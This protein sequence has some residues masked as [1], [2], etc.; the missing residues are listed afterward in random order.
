MIKGLTI[1]IGSILFII[2]AIV[3]I[4][5]FFK[6]S[7][8]NL[9]KTFHFAFLLIVTVWLYAFD[10]WKYSVTTMFVFMLLALPVLCLF[11]RIPFI[12]EH[13]PQR[14]KDEFKQSLIA[15][16]SMYI[17]VVA[18]GWGLMKNRSLCLAAFYAWGPGDGAAALIGKRYGR[19]KIGKLKKKSLEGSASMFILSF[20]CVAAI[21]SYNNVFTSEQTMIV[22]FFTALVT[23]VVELYTLSGYDTLFCPVAAII[24]LSLFKYLMR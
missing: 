5:V 16:A 10:D 21:L 15:A 24:T 18:I 22:S 4:M 23:T 19:T 3:F 9:R 14:K 13:L 8:E 2:L 1:I 12:G 20:I 11:D 6:M 7:S 17:I